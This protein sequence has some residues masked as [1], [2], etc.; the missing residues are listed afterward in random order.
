MRKRFESQPALDSTAISNVVI[1]LNSRHQ[2]P[3]LL[4][5]LQYIFTTPG[6]N[7]EVFTILEQSIMSGK[8]KTGRLGMSLWEILVMGVVRLNLDIDYDAL[9][10]N[11]N[12]HLSLRGILGVRSKAVFTIGKQYKLQTIKDNVGLLDQQTLDKINTVVVKAGHQLKKKEAEEN[13]KM[14]LEL[15]T[16]SYVVESNIHFPTDLNLLWDSLRKSLDTISHILSEM[17]LPNWRKIKTWYKK[18]KKHY[19]RTSNIHQRK[20]ANYKYRLQQATQEYLSI[21]KQINAKIEDS[22]PLIKDS[23]SIEVHVL[24]ED[25]LYYKLMAVKH[26]DLVNRRILQEEKIPHH[27]KIFSIFEPHVE[28]IQKGKAGN[29]VELGHNCLITTD[30][31]HF[32]IDHRVMVKEQDAHQP[33]TL[34]KRLKE[35]YPPKDY[36]YE[37]I[38]FDRGFYSKL[39][40]DKLSKEVETLIMPS[41]GKPSKINRTAKNEN[42][43]KSTNEKK[44]TNQHS[45]VEANINE[46]ECCGVNK[47]PDRGIE[48]FMRYVAMGVL[49]YNI[50]RMGKIIIQQKMEVEINQK[51]K[52]KKLKKAA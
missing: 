47:V 45:A 12:N 17:H 3:Q 5:G 24:Q 32:I 7:E 2:L 20:G 33:I 29:K 23:T 6:L 26:I 40:K 44:L 15:K 51:K 14:N 16:D 8:K 10:D 46:L 31:Y 19:R 52:A 25:L 28:W 36:N 34:M 41:K 37:S 13:Q 18:A 27:E 9:H 30:Q 1:N 11:V 48:G 42:I 4:V 50:K 43:E 21:S 35:K 49:S 22:L 38:S 39:A